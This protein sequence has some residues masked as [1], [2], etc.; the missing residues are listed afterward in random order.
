VVDGI[1]MEDMKRGKIAA[2]NADVVQLV[3]PKCMAENQDKNV[4]CFKC[5]NRLRRKAAREGD[6]EKPQIDV[7]P[8]TISVV[9]DRKVAKVMI[10][11]KCNLPNK[12][13]DKYCWNCGKKIRSDSAVAASERAPR[14]MPR[15]KGIPEIDAIFNE[16]KPR[17]RK[18]R[19]RKAKGKT[20]LKSADEIKS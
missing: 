13:G 1:E 4:F 17:K 14:S 10:C 16:T 8:G 6:E 15:V 7:E 11:P 12:V 9:G 20:N 19:G 3:C 18:K 2:V 5:G